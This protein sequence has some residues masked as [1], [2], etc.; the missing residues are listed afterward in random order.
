MAVSCNWFKLGQKH[1]ANGDVLW[2]AAGGS[3]VKCALLTDSATIA[4]DTNEVW[5][6]LSANEVSGTG[7]S[8]GGASLTLSDPASGT[9]DH[10]IKLDATD[11]QWTITGTLA[12]AA[13][14][15]IVYGGASSHLLGWVDFDTTPLNPTNSTMTITWDSNGILTLTAE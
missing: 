14:Y 5:S 7:Y 11:A 4:Q 9:G 15:A 3:T 13:Q 1:I 12:A 10:Q 2:K 6:D 8:A